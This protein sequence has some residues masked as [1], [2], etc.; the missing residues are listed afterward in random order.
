MIRTSKLRITSEARH[1]QH[2]LA[3]QLRRNTF[4][5]LFHTAHRLITDHARR[6][7]RIAIETLHGH[8]ISI[9]Q[10][11]ALAA[12]EHLARLRHGVGKLP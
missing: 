7:R 6:R 11:E 12:D 5:A 4:A 8:H 2:A 10:A 9:V 3:Q 1:R